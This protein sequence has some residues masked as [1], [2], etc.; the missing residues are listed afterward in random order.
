MRRVVFL[1]WFL[2]CAARY[3]A[4]QTGFDPRAAVPPDS[5][6]TRL[7]R[8]GIRP[9][10]L[11]RRFDEER[12]LTGLKKYTKRK[13][14]AGKAAAAVFRFTQRQEERTGL[15]AQLLDR[16][17][18]Q[19]NYKVIRRIN[20]RTLDAFGYSLR[21]STRRPGS[22]WERAGN[23]LH[24]R[25]APSRVRQVLTFRVGHLLEPQDLAES[26]RLLRQTAE[27]LDARVL[28]NER[29]TTR[30]SVDI[31]VVTTDVFSLTGGFDLGGAAAGVVRV[32]D[33]NFLGLG[34]KLRNRYQYGR[35]LPQAW[36]YEGSY[37]V[38][39]RSFLTAEARY[40]NQYQ[41]QTGGVSLRR[42]FYSITTKYAGAFSVDFYDRGVV[43]PL[44]QPTETPEFQ[45]LRYATQDA[46]LGRSFRLRSYDLG[47]ENPGRLIVSGRVLRSDY[48]RRPA[49]DS[50]ASAPIYRN[51]TL[52]LGTV[53]YS[54]RRY[55][56]DQYLFGFGRTEDVPTGTLLSF[57]AGMDLSREI[58]RR[59]L[60]ARLAAAG[61]NARAGYL[62]ASA[63]LGAFQRTGGAARGG[64]EQGLL[65]AETLYF[66]RLLH[67]GNYQFRHSLSSRTTLGINRFET[68]SLGQG[69]GGDR[70]LRGFRA[71]QSL[72]PTSRM[73]LNYETTM[74]TPLSFLG[75]RLAGVAFADAAWI[76]Q[77]A[78]G[79]SPFGR[80]SVPYTGFG[81][82]LRFRNEF[83]AIRTF[84]VLLGFYPRGQLTP[85]GLRLFESSRDAYQFSDFSFGQ[86]GI[87]QYQ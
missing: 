70:G 61:Y 75:F 35:S 76:S 60:A 28:V 40:R 69:I 45:P 6:N 84:Q 1:C 37:V 48:S 53:G 2:L 50:S 52:L 79:G 68:E 63:E 4:G 44:N 13:T 66:T 32:G 15:D 78:G 34:H 41:D 8:A 23:T 9:D 47:Y 26:E 82:G 18:D 87:A 49:F 3:A 86:P 67:R 57:T 85:N 80:S 22:F 39:F 19:H 72:F 71:G 24:V 73:V 30:D 51:S 65:S 74:F 58:P 21:D 10:S 33:L 20:I 81:L 59:Y 29:T 11:R 77:R 7:N 27:L 17:F 31:E 55:Y 14:I 38:P 54:V 46:W 62:Y 5:L 56:K 83:T 16:Q 25:T 64:W 36:S 12:I 43:P 42:D